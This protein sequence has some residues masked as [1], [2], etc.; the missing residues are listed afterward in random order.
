MWGGGCRSWSEV[1]AGKIKGEMTTEKDGGHLRTSDYFLQRNY[2]G[3]EQR[4]S[5]SFLFPPHIQARDCAS[6]HCETAA[7]LT[8]RGPEE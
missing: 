5:G 6:L 7:G 4:T 8:G 1:G 2:A 3:R